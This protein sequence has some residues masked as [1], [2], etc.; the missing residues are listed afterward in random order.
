MGSN[1]MSSEAIYAIGIIVIY[2]ISILVPNIVFIIIKK[3]IAHFKNKKAKQ[4]E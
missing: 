3:A 1:N 2:I 4:L